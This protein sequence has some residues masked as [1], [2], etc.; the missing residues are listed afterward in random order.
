MRGSPKTVARCATASGVMIFTLRHCLRNAGKSREIRESIAALL[1]EWHDGA[2]SENSSERSAFR[3]PRGWRLEAGGWRL[4]EESLRP[5]PS[6][7]R[8]PLSALRSPRGWR[9]EEESLRPPLSEW[10]EFCIS[11]IVYI[12]SESKIYA[13]RRLTHP[14]DGRIMEFQSRASSR[15]LSG[16]GCR[17]FSEIFSEIS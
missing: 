15:R 16:T 7:L 6:A 10:G 4:E 14:A 13:D 2:W 8:S 17:S 12:T 11:W 9:L 3:S 5:P 1:K